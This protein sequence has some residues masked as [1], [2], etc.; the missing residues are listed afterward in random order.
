MGARKY[1]SHLQGFLVA[2]AYVIGMALVYC[3]LGASFAYLGLLSGS[4]MQSQMVLYSVALIFFILALSCFGLFNLVLPSSLLNR[5]SKIGGSGFKGA[6]FMGLVAGL[7]AAP[8]TGPVLAFILTFIAENQNLYR[9]IGMMAS[10]SFGMGLPFLFLGTFSS[11]ISR[12][13]ASGPWMQKV[14]FFLGA[15]IL[16]T[17]FYYLSLAN[18]SIGSFISIFS[19]LGLGFLLFNITLGL[20]LLFTPFKKSQ[21][22]VNKTLLPSSAVAILTLS[23]SALLLLLSDQSLGQEQE[24]SKLSWHLIDHESPD[25]A[26]EQT[27]ARAKE[28]KKRVLLDFYADWCVACRK[29]SKETLSNKNVSQVLS[30]FV[31][32]KID[33]SKTSEKLQLIEKRFNVKGLPTLIFLNEMGH[34]IPPSPVVGFVKPADLLS[35]IPK[36]NKK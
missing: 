12:L 17:S 25:D 16:A 35:K 34:I 8:C 20:F 19:D 21:D 29:L 11:L 30:D 6:F 5:L 36:A 24:G 3:T 2:S 22:L 10:F 31:L 13:P 4:I 18:H 27:L 14:K 28:Q 32:I 7:V 1:D 15:V 33:S 23:L 9:G 26:L